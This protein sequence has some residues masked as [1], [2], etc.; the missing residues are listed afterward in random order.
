M[1]SLDGEGEAML[2]DSHGG[3]TPTSAAEPEKSPRESREPS[4]SPRGDSAPRQSPTGPEQT[5][6]NACVHCGKELNFAEIQACK[7][8][9]CQ[10]MCEEEG[11]GWG[12]RRISF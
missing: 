7:T 12:P 4:R 3:A 8:A 1:A 5:V 10:L 6:A 9:H 11:L 2:V